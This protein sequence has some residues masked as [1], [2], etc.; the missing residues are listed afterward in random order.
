MCLEVQLIVPVRVHFADALDTEFV[1]ALTGTIVDVSLDPFTRA[2]GDLA[3]AER[4]LI[5]Q[6]I[7]AVALVIAGAWGHWTTEVSVGVSIAVKTAA[8]AVLFG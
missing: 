8:D 4:G 3:P 5:G 2:S 6:A 7:V 1:L